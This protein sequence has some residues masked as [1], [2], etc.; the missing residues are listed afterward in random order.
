MDTS[1]QGTGS[2]GKYDA[3]IYTSQVISAIVNGEA[4]LTIRDDA[5]TVSSL[6]DSVEIPFAE[7]TSLTLAD[8]SVT[9]VSDSGN[10]TF[11]R[12]GNWCQPFYNSL[13]SA[14]NDA[15]LRSMFIS[16]APIVTARGRYDD[17]EGGVVSGVLSDFRVYDNCVVALPPDSG[18]RRVPLCFVTAVDRGDYNLILTLDSN[19]NYCYAKLG[20]DTAPFADAIE[21]Q[22]RKLRE[23]SLSAVREFDPL[24]SVAQASQIARIMPRGAA[25]PINKLSAIAPSFTNAVEKMIAN[26]RV[27]EFY[28]AL[29]EI[30]DRESIFFG[31]RNSFGDTQS[32]DNMEI[33]GDSKGSGFS[34]VGGYSEGLGRARGVADSAALGESEMTGSYGDANGGDSASIA[35]ILIVPSPDEQYAAVEFSE[36]NTATYVYK[37]GGDF[38]GF[39]N[40]LN[41]ALEAIDFRRD[42]IRLSDEELRTRNNSDYIMA[43]KRTKALQLVRANFAG[44]VIHSGIETW[45]SKLMG[46]WSNG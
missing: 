14:Y 13:L 6:F 40:K 18:A 28:A 17:A 29:K 31:F 26:T 11:S 8:Y 5:L 10:Y 38:P 42:V 41:R 37:T 32:A 25:A 35:F 21:R 45:K 16:G 7:I 24:L 1:S 44:R 15:V 22:I 39:A 23:E 4:K 9:I 43:V 46:L 36:S 3:V 19:E 30:C 27:A 2:A 12:L 34:E 33:S 20:Y